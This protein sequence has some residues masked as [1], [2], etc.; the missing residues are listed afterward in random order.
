MTRDNYSVG[1][2]GI[3]KSGKRLR[4]SQLRVGKVKL[5]YNRHRQQEMVEKR[6]GSNSAATAC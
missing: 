4:F 1:F 2:V 3:M 6:G 5:T